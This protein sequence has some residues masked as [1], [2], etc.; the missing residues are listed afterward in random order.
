MF[1]GCHKCEVEHVLKMITTLRMKFEIHVP[2]QSSQ[3]SCSPV[4]PVC[5]PLRASLAYRWD[6]NSSFIHFLMLR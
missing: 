4:Q 2:S 1:L 6:G 3:L 5:A